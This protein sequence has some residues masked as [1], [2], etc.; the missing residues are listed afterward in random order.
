LVEDIKGA[1]GAVGEGLIIE[2]S[3]GQGNW[4]RVPWAAIFEPSVTDTATKGYYP[5]Y[6]FDIANGRVHLSINQGTTSVRNEFGRLTRNVLA[7]RAAL[8]RKRVQDYL[9]R[10]PSSDISLGED[11]GLGGDYAAGHALGIAYRADQLPSEESLRI[12]LIN[13]VA[14]YRALLFR[15]GLDF[16]SDTPAER[17]GTDS[18]SGSID[19]QRQYK[20]HRRIERNAKASRLAKAFHGCVCQACGFDF[21]ARYGPIGA[22]FIEVHHLVPISSLTEGSRVRYEIA[23]DFAVLCANCHR[24]IHRYENPAD[25]EALRSSLR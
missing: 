19:E 10:L 1:L 3:A 5:V 9:D 6:L 4:A 12:D 21:E 22:G 18:S 15:G 23:N 16:E 20:M 13:A 7:D 24:I 2:G 8:M 14:C 17:A 25:L 11:R